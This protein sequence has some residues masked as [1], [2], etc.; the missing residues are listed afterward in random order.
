MPWLR[1]LTDEVHTHGAAV[2]TQ[3]THLGRRTSNFSGD[4]LPLVYPSALREPAHRSFP[5]VAE[6][7]DLDRI[8]QDYADAASRCVEAGLD[9]IEHVYARTIGEGGGDGTGS[10]TT[11]TMTFTITVNDTEDPTLSP[12]I[13][14]MLRIVEPWRS[15]IERCQAWCDHR[16]GPRRLTSKVFC[17][18]GTS[19]SIDRPR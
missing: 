4:W 14:A 7:W 1:R 8:V 18:R 16:S 12:P 19:M 5:K 3:V 2:M 10:P 15:F 6:E 13:D 9:G 17:Q 11:D